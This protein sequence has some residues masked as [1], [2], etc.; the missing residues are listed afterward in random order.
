M[1]IHC[2]RT[3]KPSSTSY[4]KFLFISVIFGSSS[5]SIFRYNLLFH[6]YTALLSPNVTESHSHLRL[7]TLPRSLSLNEKVSY[8]S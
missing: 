7:S 4:L 5:P 3:T 6:T 1:K 8:G 2:F